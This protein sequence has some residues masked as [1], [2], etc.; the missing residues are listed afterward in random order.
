[1]VTASPARRAARR[2]QA[3]EDCCSPLALEPLSDAAATELAGAFKALADPAR[4]RLL[5]LILAHE[6]G[7][8]CVCDLNGPIDLS[9]P[10]ISHHLKILADAGL[11][12]REKRGVWAYYRVVSPALG[13]LAQALTFGPRG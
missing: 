2:A 8:A 9:Q 3:L 11:V 1:M 10:T 7:E 12:E 5:S 4:L 6:D 13:A